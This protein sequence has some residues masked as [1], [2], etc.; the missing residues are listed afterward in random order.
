MQS[1]TTLNSKLIKLLVDDID[2]DQI[3]P[4]RF[5]KTTDK[6]GLGQHLF[7]NWRYNEDGSENGD[8][9]LNQAAM[10][11]RKVLLSGDNFGCG[12]SRE[13]APWALSAWGFRVII[14]TSFADIFRSNA[15][16]NGLLLVEVSK[17]H[18]K[19]LTV[20]D[21]DAEVHIDLS[22]RTLQLADKEP[23]EFPIDAFSKRC[24]ADGLDQLG[25]LQ[26]FQEA[27]EAYE[28]GQ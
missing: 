6:L 8:F 18:H 23:I 7:S 20:A 13:H 12:S 25:Y 21:S 3:I 14:S 1:F 27:I 2:T 22:T 16:K 4:A 26:S 17:E 15:L 24:L 10:K 28:R 9:A 19:E 5:L 11:G